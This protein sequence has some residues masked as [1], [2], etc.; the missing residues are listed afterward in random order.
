MQAKFHGCIGP[1]CETHFDAERAPTQNKRWHGQRL[2]MQVNSR[3]R[4]AGQ[5][6]RLQPTDLTPIPAPS[7]IFDNRVQPTNETHTHTHTSP[8]DEHQTMSSL[9]RVVAERAAMKPASV[10]S[11]GVSRY[12]YWRVSCFRVN[13]L[14]AHRPAARKPAG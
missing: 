8:K 7:E 2:H 14:F 1:V 10:F 5:L 12:R 9:P 3:G 6:A 11:A 4:F 13:S